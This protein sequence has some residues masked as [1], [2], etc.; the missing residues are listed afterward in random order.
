M[1]NE[2]QDQ[3]GL[4]AQQYAGLSQDSGSLVSSVTNA[5]ASEIKY[6]QNVMTNPN[7][8]P[9]QQAAAVQMLNSTI[10]SNQAISSSLS[11]S[12]YLPQREA[13]TDIQLVNQLLQV[14]ELQMEGK[15]TAEAIVEVKAQAKTLDQQ[16]YILSQS[17]S[18]E[19]RYETFINSIAQQYSVTGWYVT[20]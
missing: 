14:V 3:V 16:A 15:P 10:A 13:A 9:A 7:D 2:I 19:T 20:Q 11:G 1:V 17:A 18:D 5:G 4:I 6:L 12:F 8:T